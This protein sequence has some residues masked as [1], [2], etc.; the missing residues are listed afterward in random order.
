MSWRPYTIRRLTADEQ[1]TL[2]VC[3]VQ[4]A[5]MSCRGSVQY[6][7]VYEY[8]CLVEAA[9]PY[10]GV[11]TDSSRRLVCELCKDTLMVRDKW[12]TKPRTTRTTAPKSPLSK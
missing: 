12:Q 5:T 7:A 9:D 1:T 2:R 4:C 10:S 6:E 8:Q 11:V 3:G